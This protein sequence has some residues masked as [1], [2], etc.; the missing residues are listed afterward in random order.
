MTDGLSANQ[1]IKHALGA[2]VTQTAVVECATRRQVP[3]QVV[4]AA[5]ARA[6]LH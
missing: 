4:G 5:H 3:G 2:L 6:S 1:A